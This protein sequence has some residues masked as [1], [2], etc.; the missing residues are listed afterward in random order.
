MEKAAGRYRYERKF[1][2]SELSTAEIEAIV[3]MHPALFLEHY[4]PRF[5]NNIYCDT[6]ELNNYHDTIDGAGRRVK[7]RI[8]WYHDLFGRIDKPILE[9]KI[10]RGLVGTKQCFPLESFVLDEKFNIQTIHQAFRQADI[11]ESTCLELLSF[12]PTLLNR[13][14]RSYFQSAD[15]HFRLTIDRNMDF[16]ALDSGMNTF[17]HTHTDQHNTVVELKYNQDQNQAAERIAGLFPF[18]LSRNSKYING[19]ENLVF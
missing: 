1:V 12:E 7:V 13:Y 17:C 9:L 4:P 14:L 15:G 10:K 8:R 5:V 6:L 11:P 18:R 19:I 3:K 16:Y 2:V